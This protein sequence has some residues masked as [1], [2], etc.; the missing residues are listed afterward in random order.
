M[1]EETIT[2]VVSSAAL[3][4]PG[5]TEGGGASPVGEFTHYRSRREGAGRVYRRRHTQKS[6]LLHVERELSV[7]D[8]HAELVMKI[9]S[10]LH[11]PPPTNCFEMFVFRHWQE[12]RKS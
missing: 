8:W 11:T 1:K 12:Q 7:A 5:A 10:L 9:H 2:A 4:F 6:S 3:S